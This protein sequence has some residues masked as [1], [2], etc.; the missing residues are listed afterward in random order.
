ME[1]LF[2]I[3][4]AV[5]LLR[6]LTNGRSA[7]TGW[8]LTMET[9]SFT[10]LA[11]CVEQVVAE[12]IL[13]PAARLCAPESLRI[14]QGDWLAA[15][16]TNHCRRA[17]CAQAWKSRVGNYGG[18]GSMELLGPAYLLPASI[19]LTNSACLRD[20]PTQQRTALLVM[21][22]WRE[23]ANDIL[24]VCQLVAHI[25]NSECVRNEESLYHPDIFCMDLVAGQRSWKKYQSFGNGADGFEQV[26]S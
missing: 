19:S 5:A 9:V 26:G 20:H 24:A 2:T 13:R 10:A 1:I 15:A 14:A 7:S 6:L 17:R 4:A 25:G 3:T 21:G 8:R 11:T 12:V 18:Q 22:V 23:D 16:C